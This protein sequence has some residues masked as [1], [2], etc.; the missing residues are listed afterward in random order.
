MSHAV[1]RAPDWLPTSAVIGSIAGLLIAGFPV[2]VLAGAAIGTGLGVVFRAIVPSSK[3]SVANTDKEQRFNAEGP[4][5]EK[6]SEPCLE[7]KNTSKWVD[8]VS[9]SSINDERRR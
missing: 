7:Q 5:M 1:F 3:P 8:R 9:S 6:A 2:G 4:A